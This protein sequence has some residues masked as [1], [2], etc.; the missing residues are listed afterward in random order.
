MEAQNT[1]IIK[2]VLSR[3]SN[4][5]SMPMP[6]FKLYYRAMVTKNIAQQIIG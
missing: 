4:T 2:V 5:M 6:N 1:Q 3:K